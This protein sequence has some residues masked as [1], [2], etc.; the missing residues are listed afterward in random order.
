MR[1]IRSEAPLCLNLRG[2]CPTPPPRG[3]GGGPRFPSEGSDAKHPERSAPSEGNVGHPLGR[4][5]THSAMKTFVSFVPPLLRL[6]A[7]TR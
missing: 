1:S 3:R 2:G 4:Y 7:N 6:E 5:S